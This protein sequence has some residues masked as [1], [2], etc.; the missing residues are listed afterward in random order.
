MAVASWSSVIVCGRPP[1]HPHEC[2]HIYSD[3]AHQSEIIT[4]SL[5]MTSLTPRLGGC[6][7]TS[8]TVVCLPL[9]E[10]Q[11][12]KILTSESWTVL[13]MVCLIS[14]RGMSA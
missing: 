6:I 10:Q 9:Y 8:Q 3:A 14:I 1:G 12:V 4:F 11:L 2:N 13:T 5:L 7:Q